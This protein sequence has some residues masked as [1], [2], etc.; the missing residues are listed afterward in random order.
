MRASSS[1]SNSRKRSGDSAIRVYRDNGHQPWRTYLDW[2]QGAVDGTGD[3]MLH[4]TGGSPHSLRLTST[5]V[6]LGDTFSG[7][8]TYSG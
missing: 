6:D 4:S 2:V 3:A 8:P 7:L 5:M 1:A